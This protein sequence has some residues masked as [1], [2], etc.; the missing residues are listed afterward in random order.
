MQLQLSTWQ[1]IDEYLRSSKGC[2]TILVENDF[3]RQT[4]LMVKAPGPG[5]SHLNTEPLLLLIRQPQP[6]LLMPLMVIVVI[7]VIVVIDNHV[8]VMSPVIVMIVLCAHRTTG[9]T[10][11]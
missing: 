2:K 10:W 5:T 6:F 11:S 3:A 1:E 9:T 4:D 8:V 7:V